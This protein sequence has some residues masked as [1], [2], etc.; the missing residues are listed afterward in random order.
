VFLPALI[1][2]VALSGGL[3]AL[4]ARN[5]RSRLIE[6][7][8]GATAQ[9]AGTLTQLEMATDALMS[10]AARALGEHVH[11]EGPL[12]NEGLVQL[13]ADLGVTHLYIRK[14]LVVDLIFG[15]SLSDHH[16]DIDAH[17]VEHVE[18]AVTEAVNLQRAGRFL[19]TGQ[20]RLRPY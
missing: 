2:T 12:S 17:R 4:L 8:Q 3:Y 20:R 7:Y 10:A 18:V 1:I 16:L 19:G 11:R 9:L 14:I 6:H 15:S 5:T 13:S